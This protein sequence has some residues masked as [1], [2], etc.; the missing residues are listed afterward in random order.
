MFDYSL[1]PDAALSGLIALVSLGFVWARP[2]IRVLLSKSQEHLEDSD[3]YGIT[4]IA[5]YITS[6]HNAHHITS[7][8]HKR[9]LE[10]QTNTFRR[11]IP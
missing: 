5:L 11:P 9:Q 2:K 3:F 8:P 1:S 4:K 6:P 7:L 10:K